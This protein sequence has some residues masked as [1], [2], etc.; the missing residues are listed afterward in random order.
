MIKISA[1]ITPNVPG[2]KEVHFAGRV[3][4]LSVR[5]G[6]RVEDLLVKLADKLGSDFT[7][8]VYD[9]VSHKLDPKMLIMINGK[10]LSA[11]EGL[12]KILS[13][14]DKITIGAVMLGG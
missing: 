5:R 12:K 13:D 9:P 4:A 14:N 7:S 2:E 1:R 10:V 11:E 8:M 6:S 3:F